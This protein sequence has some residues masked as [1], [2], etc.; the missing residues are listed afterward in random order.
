MIG[1]IVY[2]IDESGRGMYQGN[3][4]W[5]KDP[6]QEEAENMEQYF[7]TLPHIKISI[8]ALEM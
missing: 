6:G 5:A 2:T 1:E 7:L 8:G 3:K 4:K